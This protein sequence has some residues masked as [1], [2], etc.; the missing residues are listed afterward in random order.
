MHRRY[1]DI[2]AVP[3]VTLLHNKIGSMM[4]VLNVSSLGFCMSNTTEASLADAI[5]NRFNDLHW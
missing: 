2:A 4:K 5:G 1:K 3:F